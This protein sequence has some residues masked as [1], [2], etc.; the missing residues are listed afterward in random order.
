M[1]GT[2]RAENL[3]GLPPL[4]RLLVAL[5][6]VG[7]VGFTSV[8]VVYNAAANLELGGR[9]EAV[10]ALL[11]PRAAAAHFAFAYAVAIGTKA[12]LRAMDGAELGV[13]AVCAAAAVAAAVSVAVWVLFFVRSRHEEE[14]RE[15]A[16]LVRRLDEIRM[17][18]Q[19][20]PVGP[21]GSHPGIVKP[22]I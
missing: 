8:W 10:A 9:W 20:E 1:V 16:E 3:N 21:G 19:K 2:V 15:Q 14:R 5:L 17:T 4:M 11:P 13:S 6:L 7:A 18:G 12:A 22:F